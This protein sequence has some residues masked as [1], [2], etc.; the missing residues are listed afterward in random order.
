M[1]G[2]FRFGSWSIMNLMLGT[3]FTR[4]DFKWIDVSV[5]AFSLLWNNVD[6]TDRREV[7]K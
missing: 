3:L 6:H 7:F 1:F 5:S 4:S 2:R